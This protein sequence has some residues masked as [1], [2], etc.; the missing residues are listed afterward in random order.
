MHVFLPLSAPNKAAG[1]G[2]SAPAAALI[3][4]R[5]PTALAVP[6]RRTLR[7]EKAHA[8][9]STR[10]CAGIDDKESLC[11]CDEHFGVSSVFCG[12]VRPH[13]RTCMSP[14]IS[15]LR[16]VTHHED[17]IFDCSPSVAGLC[18]QFVLHACKPAMEVLKMPL[19]SAHKKNHLI[20]IVASTSQMCSSVF[21]LTPIYPKA[22]AEML[23]VSSTNSVL[24]TTL[25]FAWIHVPQC[26]A[27]FASLPRTQRL[28]CT[29]VFSSTF[30]TT[31]CWGHFKR[32]LEVQPCHAERP[33]VPNMLIPHRCFL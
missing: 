2:E 8:T 17:S 7:T 32:S 23:S 4:R 22:P 6:E 14:R 28:A 11:V 21:S 10:A 1:S 12:G 33:L 24:R 19:L 15:F 3:C 9:M 20:S 26:P 13:E 25:Y 27:Y 29:L 5:F 30:A 16:E 18:E 31:L